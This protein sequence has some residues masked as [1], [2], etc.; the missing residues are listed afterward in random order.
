MYCLAVECYYT[1]VVEELGGQ[2]SQRAV[3]R[4]LR[5]LKLVRGS[6]SSSRKARGGGS[7]SGRVDVAQLR[8]LYEQFKDK[9]RSIQR[10][11]WESNAGR[12]WPKCG[13]CMSNTRWGACKEQGGA[14]LLCGHGSSAGAVKALQGQGR[15][16]W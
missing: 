8:E 11:R 6:A 3:L 15:E 4:R 16:Y 13:S 12:M 5:K 9:V 2:V 7:R 1:Q 10:A 14:V